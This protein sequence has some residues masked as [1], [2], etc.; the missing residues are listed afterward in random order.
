MQVRR[1]KVHSD[2]KS[3][4]VVKDAT[5]VIKTIILASEVHSMTN[6]AIKMTT[7]ISI[8]ALI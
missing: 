7:R 5:K 6:K 1:I 8:T 3:L 4:V 2:F